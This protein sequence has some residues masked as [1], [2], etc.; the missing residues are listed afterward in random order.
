[1]HSEAWIMSLSFSI[2]IP[3]LL[4]YTTHG[5]KDLTTNPAILP[6]LFNMFLSATIVYLWSL[7]KSCRCCVELIDDAGAVLSPLGAEHLCGE[8]STPPDE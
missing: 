4:L 3:N 7:H 5:G 2:H 8:V 6:V 1:M